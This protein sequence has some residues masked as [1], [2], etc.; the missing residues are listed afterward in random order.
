MNIFFLIYGLI[1]LISFLTMTY[2]LVKALLGW[3]DENGFHN[4]SKNKYLNKFL[5]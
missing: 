5:K 4:K 3:E 2:L 1:L